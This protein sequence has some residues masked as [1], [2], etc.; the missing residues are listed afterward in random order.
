M[1]FYAPLS[2]SEL[3]TSSFVDR[4]FAHLARCGFDSDR[5]SEKFGYGSWFNLLR[6]NR[7]PRWGFVRGWAM[8]T[9]HFS[10]RKGPPVGTRTMRTCLGGSFFFILRV[11][12]P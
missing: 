8:P 3:G 10:S 5:E 9:S 2:R 6:F 12:A 1:G 11:H 7:R 4:S